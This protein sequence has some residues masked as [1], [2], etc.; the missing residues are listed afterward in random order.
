MKIKIPRDRQSQ[1][2]SASISTLDRCTVTANATTCPGAPPTDIRMGIPVLSPL[3]TITPTNIPP[4]LHA[5][6]SYSSA[7]DATPPFWSPS[8]PP[9]AR[10]PASLDCLPPKDAS[11]GGLKLSLSASSLPHLPFQLPAGMHVTSP[12]CLGKSG[13]GNTTIGTLPCTNTFGIIAII[14]SQ[15][16]FSP[17]RFLPPSPY[18]PFPLCSLHI[19]LSYKQVYPLS[20]PI[21]LSGYNK[22]PLFTHPARS[23]SLIPCRTP[24]IQNATPKSLK[25]PLMSLNS[26]RLTCHSAFPAVL[27]LASAR[28][29]TRN[30]PAAAH[31]LRPRYL[32]SFPS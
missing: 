4:F 2:T 15:T 8:R 22:Q 29:H 32:M 30:P 12:F 9:L 25:Y 7:Q 21:L 26:R 27:H 19:P 14:A 28:W 24:H 5:S 6:I 11:T 1:A 13:C 23:P 20:L 3:I 16:P 17:S 10:F 31:P 18:F